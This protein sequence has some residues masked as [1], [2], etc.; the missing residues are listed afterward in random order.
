[1]GSN[2]RRARTLPQGSDILTDLERRSEPMKPAQHEQNGK[3][4]MNTSAGYTRSALVDDPT[5][6]LSNGCVLVVGYPPRKLPRPNPQTGGWWY[7]HTGSQMCRV[8]GM[9]RDC[10]WLVDCKASGLVQVDPDSAEA[11][12]WAKAHGLS[13]DRAWVLKSARGLKTLYRVPVDELPPAY[14]DKTHQTADIGNRLC[15]VP[16]SI[17]PSGMRI[18]W[19]SGHSPQD[20]SM[21]ELAALPERLLGAWWELKL[22]NLLRK[23]PTAHPPGW[24]GMVFDA[25]VEHI[26][27]NGGWLRPSGSGGMN[28]N[29]PLH[30]DKTPSFS[31]HPEKGWKC[32]SGCGEGRLT[33]LAFRLGISII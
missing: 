33:S 9:V 11:L 4:P 22:P 1:M 30:D 28:G 21:S 18:S 25:I 7:I 6:Y 16:P 2:D 32:F 26:E 20:I 19:V 15:L 23:K 8:S 29:C 31:I 24:L 10:N 13:S 5:T 27:A 3:T 17:H 14:V 12:E